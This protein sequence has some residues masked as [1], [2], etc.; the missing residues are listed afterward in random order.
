MMTLKR[1]LLVLAA[2]GLAAFLAYLFQD[3]VEA[4]V[5]MP[6]LYTWWILGL[7]YR[8]IPQQAYWM[9]LLTALI[10]FF[11]SSFYVSSRRAKPRRDQSSPPQG[12]VER[13]NQ[14]IEQRQS[15]VYFKWQLA[16][17]LA[18]LADQILVYQDRRNPGRSLSGQGWHPPGQVERYLKAGLETTF[19]DYPSVGPFS[20]T[21]PTPFDIDI[22]PVVAFLESELEANRGD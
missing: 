9:V 22:E 15:G 10:Y 20:S 2:L 1:I 14:W 3:L 6:A 12:P 5:V 7:V 11:V 4:L 17:A 13:L 18:E 19:T 16:R 21:P 8:A